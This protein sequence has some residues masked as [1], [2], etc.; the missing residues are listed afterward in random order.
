MKEQVENNQNQSV[1][2]KESAG[3]AV[4]VAILSELSSMGAGHAATALSEVLQQPVTIEVPRVHRAPAH[5]LLKMF[6]LHEMPTTAL[7]ITLA[8]GPECD[9]L[10]MMEADE[11]RKVASIMTMTAVEELD[12]SMEAS[13]TEELANIL[14]GSFLS[15]ISDFAG[16]QLMTAPPERI[17]DAF[18]AI[19]DFI[20]A[21]NSLLQSETLLFDILFKASEKVSKCMLLLFPSPDMRETLV[22]KSKVMVG[23]V[24]IV[25]QPCATAGN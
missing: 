24:D 2:G 18:D 15:A 20:L 25:E 23:A 12:P 17:V 3:D 21:K 1:E 6:G 10:M 5:L 22:E 14:V 4:D 7:Y 11:A 16:I 9:I 13:A 19:L 8:S